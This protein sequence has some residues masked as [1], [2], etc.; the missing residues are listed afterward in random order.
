MT[1][2]SKS[3]LSVHL[4]DMENMGLVEVAGEEKA[5]G[6]IPTKFFRLV[7][8]YEEKMAQKCC[9]KEE[10][11]IAE[12]KQFLQMQRSFAQTQVQMIQNWLKYLDL[13]EKDF[14][15]EITNGTSDADVQSIKDIKIDDS[16]DD[17]D[18]KG[19]SG[20][21]LQEI[22]KVIRDK[23]KITIV[24]FYDEENA[25][26]FREEILTIYNQAEERN[27]EADARDPDHQNPYYVGVQIL[28]IKRAIDYSLA[29]DKKK[30]KSKKKGN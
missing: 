3:T 27:R 12:I 10:D 29:N 26:K 28:P 18:Y 23:A 7:S 17:E 30:G 11:N 22:K 13:L 4:S 14:D 19:N 8:N 1:G 6:N 24:S 25:T 20:P 9:K 21:A 16:L 2:K 5:R 15:D